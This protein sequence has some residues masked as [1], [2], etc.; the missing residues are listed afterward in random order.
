M[1]VVLFLTN[2]SLLLLVLLVLLIFLVLLAFLSSLW[3]LRMRLNKLLHTISE[4]FPTDGTAAIL[5]NHLHETLGFL[6]SQLV[7]ESLEAL[8]HFIWTQHA[9]LLHIRLILFEKLFL[10][11]LIPFCFDDTTRRAISTVW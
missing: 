2:R 11:L 3:W 7:A 1:C 4:L 5:V 6:K 8:L 9:V 10:T